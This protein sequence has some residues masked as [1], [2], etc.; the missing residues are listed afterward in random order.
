[1]EDASQPVLYGYTALRLAGILLQPFIPN[2]A[3]ELLDRLGVPD[4]ERGWDNAGWPIRVDAS[5][6]VRRLEGSAAMEQDGHLFPQVNQ[7]GRIKST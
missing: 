4:T 1:M 5:E 7:G 2:K 3:G 6:I